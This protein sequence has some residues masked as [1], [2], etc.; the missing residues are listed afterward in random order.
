ME[1]L[2]S[3]LSL[4]FFTRLVK[5]VHSSCSSGGGGTGG[6]EPPASRTLLSRFPY[7]YFPPPAL[8]R[9]ALVPWF[10]IASSSHFF[11]NLT[12]YATHVH[13]CRFTFYDLYDVTTVNGFTIS[14]EVSLF[15]QPKQKFSFACL[16]GSLNS[17]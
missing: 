11:C 9:A 12:A 16:L 14:P 6:S 4:P 8:F 3:I 13:P 7:L 2:E 1:T 15:F 17:D 10:E 5:A